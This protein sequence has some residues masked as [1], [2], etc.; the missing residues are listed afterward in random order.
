MAHTS[1]KMG[2]ILQNMGLMTFVSTTSLNLGLH[3]CV[4]G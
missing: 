1:R 4:F 3:M 2:P